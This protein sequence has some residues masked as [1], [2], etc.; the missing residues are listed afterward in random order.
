MHRLVHRE[1]ERPEVN[2]L[3]RAVFAVLVE[4]EAERGGPLD[5]LF[6]LLF[7]HG[8]DG[9]LA[10][11]QTF[12]DE[13]DA[14]HGFARS[15]RPRHEQA[16]AF[17]DAA[18]H[19]VVEFWIAGGKPLPALDAFGFIPAEA[20]SAREGLQAILGDAERVQAGHGLLAA[21]LHDLHLADDRIALDALGEPEQPVGHG[22][23][24]VVAHLAFV[25]FADQERGRLPTGQ[26]Q[27]QPLDEP[28]EFHFGRDVALRLA[29]HGAERVHHH[30]ARIGRLD[31]LDDRVEDRAEILVEH[32]LAEVDEADS[33]VHLG[34]VEERILL[35]IAQ[36]FDGRLAQYGE[37]D[38]GPLRGGVGEHDLVRERSLPAPRRAGEDVERVLGQAAAEDFVQARHAGGQLSNR[39][40]CRC[41]SGFRYAHASPRLL[42]VLSHTASG[43]ASR[44]SRSVM[45]SPR[46]VTRSPSRRAAS[47]TAAS[48]PS[49]LASATSTSSPFK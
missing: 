25:V 21:Q 46:K 37:V 29:H 43:Q 2:E 28:L 8:D 39:H 11:A 23:D 13:L 27:R 15:G 42:T 24:R 4:V 48:G 10:A 16:V 44:T 26:V 20:E 9:R 14:E 17:G 5:V 7:E 33:R 49:A 45:G 47:A 40:S 36:H 22:E 41:C 31:F 3:E 32:D 6:G 1:V 34:G 35:L 19:E 38:R 12:R 30:D 18:A